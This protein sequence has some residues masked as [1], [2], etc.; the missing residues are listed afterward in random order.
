MGYVALA[1]IALAADLALALLVAAFIRAGRGGGS[2]REP[3]VQRHLA[4]V[5]NNVLRLPS[6]LRFR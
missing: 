3:V 6:P 2:P 1:F 5:R 4:P